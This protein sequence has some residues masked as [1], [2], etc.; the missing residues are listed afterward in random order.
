MLA[1]RIKPPTLL[2]KQVTYLYADAAVGAALFPFFGMFFLTSRT[3][4]KRK[5]ATFKNP[6]LDT[7]LVMDVSLC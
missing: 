5:V 3:L 7:T 2:V 6:L 1:A 4:R